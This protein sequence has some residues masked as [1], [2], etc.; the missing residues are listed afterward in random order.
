MRQKSNPTVIG[1][2]G[3]IATGKSTVLGMLEELGAE[4]IDADRLVH[5]LIRQDIEIQ[6]SILNE[7]G[8][9]VLSSDGSI[10][11]KALG[12]IVFDNPLKLQ[13]LEDIIHPA[14]G[15]EVERVITA[16]EADGLIIEA[17]K[18]LESELVNRC[19]YIW[20]TDCP[21]DVQLGRLVSERAMTPD[22]ALTRIRVQPLQSIKLSRADII[23][24]TGGSLEWT[25]DQVDLAWAQCITGT[26]DETGR[27]IDWVS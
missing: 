26:V 25:R 3:N 23:I 17:I 15:R 6:Q 27:Q 19:D 11:R 16:T 2:T 18:L 8:D 14:V 7:F 24:D 22:E 21:E 13:V 9:Q 10:D 20:V 1:L 5:Q 4:I 12:S